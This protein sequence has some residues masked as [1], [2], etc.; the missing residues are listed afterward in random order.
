MAAFAYGGAALQ[1][2][3][4]A[5]VKHDAS[6]ASRGNV[7]NTCGAARRD[8][9]TRPLPCLVGRYWRTP[10]ALVLGSAVTAWRGNRRRSH[11]NKLILAL[12]AHTAPESRLAFEVRALEGRGMGAVASRH[13]HRGERILE[14]KPVLVVPAISN[15]SQLASWGP[16]I[17]ARLKEMNLND[18]HAFWELADSH[19]GSDGQASAVGIVRT[20]GLPIEDGTDAGS[21]GVYLTV[22]RFNHS[23]N[24][25][26][27]N[28]WQPDMG[29]EVLHATR[30]IEEG[31]ELCITYIDFFQPREARQIE[32]ERVFKFRCNCEACSGMDAAS[33]ERSDFVRHRLAQ[34][35]DAL[36]QS[37]SLLPRVV[38]KMVSL[39][40]EELDGNP[41]AKCC[42]YSIGYQVAASAHDV[43]LAG[44]MARKACEFSAMAEGEHS[45]RTMMLQ[46]CAEDPM[47]RSQAGN[48]AW[49]G[50]G[51]VSE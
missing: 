8:C 19:L 30:D 1:P 2:Q 47:Q 25:N 7:C 50:E 6:I 4:A 46:K 31:E 51:L 5:L 24:H 37:Q 35:R 42:V 11:Q 28:S 13:I 49:G 33:L 23:C 22:S 20:N 36:P 26:V 48:M 32:L 21:L 34:L 18:R 29:M 38:H 3:P 15:S 40:D 45:W 39:I 14:E 41:P 27:N 12:S 43:Q 9:T 16:K 44:E 17:E 10:V